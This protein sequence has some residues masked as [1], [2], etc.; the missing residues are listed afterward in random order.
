MNILAMDTC[1]QLLV[2]TAMSSRR[3]TWS[4]LIAVG[5]AADDCPT[6]AA[7]VD[8]VVATSPQHESYPWRRLVAVSIAADDCPTAA[9]VVDGVVATPPAARVVPLAAGGYSS[10]AAHSGENKRRTCAVTCTKQYV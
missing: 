6:A 10:A 3:V 1:V 8:G 5:I 7:V 9:A 4:R 2:L